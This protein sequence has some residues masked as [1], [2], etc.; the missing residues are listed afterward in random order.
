MAI[1][2]GFSHEKWWFS[3]A[4][5]V[6]QRV[7]V[8]MIRFIVSPFIAEH[9]VFLKYGKN[10]L[11]QPPFLD[12]PKPRIDH[13]QVITINEWCKPSPDGRFFWFWLVI[14]LPLWKI[15]KSVR[16]IIPNIWKVIKFMFQ[17]TNQDWV[18]HPIMLLNHYFWRWTPSSKV[19]P[20]VLYVFFVR[21]MVIPPE[22]I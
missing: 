19:S 14:Y 18:S 7:F 6:Y 12:F 10:H 20:H 1:Y 13:P 22:W 4:M 9:W 3:I 5:L 11:F 2:S 15:C 17:T 21:G 8:Q 16:I